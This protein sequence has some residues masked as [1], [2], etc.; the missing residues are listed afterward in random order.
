MLSGHRNIHVV[1]TIALVAVLMVLPIGPVKAA[2]LP[3]RAT[4]VT[5]R[6]HS[7]DL[8]TPQGVAGLYRR[9]RAAAEAV[10][11]QPDDTLLLYRLIWNQCVDQAIAGAVASAHSESLSAYRGRQIRGRKRPVLEA[12]EFL[13][14]RKPVAP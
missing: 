3:A 4:S 5:V 10:C 14:V 7:G 1:V 12:P 2:S 6:F 13:A 9:I 11:G 8:G